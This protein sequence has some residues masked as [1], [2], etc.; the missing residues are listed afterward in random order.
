MIIGKGFL[1]TLMKKRYI[2]NID[3][4]GN[5][6]DTTIPITRTRKI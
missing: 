1:L 2:S 4:W 6:Y 3:G 5:N